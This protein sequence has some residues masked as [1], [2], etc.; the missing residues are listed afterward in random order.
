MA[1]AT[2]QRRASSW[3][4]FY[5]YGP[6]SAGALLSP[7]RQR[8]RRR[9]LSSI[10]TGGACSTLIAPPEVGGYSTPATKDRSPGAPVI[11]TA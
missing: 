8:I 7:R 10:Q 6:P 5:G 11:A 1:F 4:P 3:T 9:A 2:E